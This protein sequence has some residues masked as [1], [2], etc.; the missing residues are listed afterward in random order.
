MALRL[1]IIVGCSAVMATEAESKDAFEKVRVGVVE[2]VNTGCFL[3]NV[4]AGLSV[5][6]A[7]AKSAGSGA[8]DEEP[9]EPSDPSKDRAGD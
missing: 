5:G 4:R 3:V 7:F 9:K 2:R 8:A 6:S 1:T